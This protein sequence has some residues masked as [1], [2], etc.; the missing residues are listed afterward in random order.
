LYRKL[1]KTDIGASV[2]NI[3]PFITAEPVFEPGIWLDGVTLQIFDG[4]ALVIDRNTRRD[5]KPAGATRY[6]LNADLADQVADELFWP[7]DK[8]GLARALYLLGYTKGMT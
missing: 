5:G 4:F 6:E 3:V 2:T 7:C 8:Q 1:I